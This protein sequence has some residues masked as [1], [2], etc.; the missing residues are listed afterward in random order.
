MTTNWLLTKMVSFNYWKAC[1]ISVSQMDAITSDV[2]SYN[3]STD[4]QMTDFHSQLSTK[5]GTVFLLDSQ[6]PLFE[7]LTTASRL[8]FYC[9]REEGVS[10][11]H[12]NSLLKY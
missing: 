12:N 11:K 9:P 6:T 7:G 8:G 4:A 5:G 10:H 3:H 2:Q 1:T